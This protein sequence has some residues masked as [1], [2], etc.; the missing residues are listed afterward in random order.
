MGFV[1]R[2]LNSGISYAPSGSEERNIILCNYIAVVVSFSALLLA[3][4]RY[5]IGKGVLETN[6]YLI[7]SCSLFFL[8]PLVLN[9]FGFVHSSRFYLSWVPPLC[10]LTVAVLALRAGGKAETSDFMSIRVLLLGLGGIP[11]LLFDL[12][13][14]LP[15]TLALVGSVTPFLFY[16]VLL[17]LFEVGYS[18]SGLNDSSYG[19]SQVRFLLAFLTIGLGFYYLKSL[20]E[21]NEDLNESLFKEL[22]HKK[23]LLQEQTENELHQLNDQLKLNIEQLSEREFILNKSQRIARIGSWEYRIE[24]GFLFW[25]DEMYEIFGLDKSFDIKAG[26]LNEALGDEGSRQLTAST[27][28]LLRTSEPFDITIRTKTPIGYF[29]WF[30]IYAFPI[31]E[32]KNAIGVRGICHDITFFKEAEEKLRAGEAKFSKVFENYP[33]F[34]MVVRETDLLVIDVNQKITSVLGFQ[35]EEVLGHSAR[36]MDLFLSE[37]E[38]QKYITS[39]ALDGYIDHECQWKRKDGRIIQVKIT[40]IRIDIGGQYY[41]MS[42]VQDITERKAA[43]EKFLKAFDLSPDL[44]LILRERDFVVVEANRKIFEISGFTREEVMGTSAD[45]EV[46]MLWGTRKRR[47]VFYRQYKTKGSVFMEAKLQRKNGETF[48]ATIS[49]RRISLSDENHMIVVIR[50][51]TERKQVETREGAR[52]IPA[53]REDQGA[54]RIVSYESGPS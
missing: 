41:R 40:G 14:P 53:E 47:E 28:N 20:I 30:R 19:F 10:V 49:A 51:I 37:E 22:E 33:D 15:L 27:I 9:R 16:D 26:N 36:A 11:F 38:R 4:S 52:E 39:Y 35:K 12:R 50:D 8:V 6:V 21:K 48:F 46:F 31:I 5:V 13:R 54:Y 24:N 2:I 17:N 23:A 7:A 1:R 18:Q 34:I 42:V 3:I 29:K 32:G 44:M 45:E 25:S 43:E